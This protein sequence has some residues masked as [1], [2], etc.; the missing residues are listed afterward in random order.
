MGCGVVD[1][2]ADED[3]RV[4][5]SVDALDSMIA[6]VSNLAQAV[7]AAAVPLGALVEY[8]GLPKRKP[9]N[10]VNSPRIYTAVRYL[11]EF[12]TIDQQRPA[13]PEFKEGKPIS[14]SSKFVHLSICKFIDTENKAAGRKVIE[15]QW[16]SKVSTEMEAWK[17]TQK[18]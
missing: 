14:I 3:A 7:E 9:G 5:A 12:W 4:K 17:K 10:V 2:N 16:K 11:C 1:T 13:S 18:T 6:A 15:P 8:S